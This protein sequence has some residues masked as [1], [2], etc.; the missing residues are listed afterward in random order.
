MREKT[1]AR[2][3]WFV[4]FRKAIGVAAM[5]MCAASAQTMSFVPEAVARNNQAVQLVKAGRNG[6]AEKL[7]RAALSA[8]SSDDLTRAKIASNLGELYRREDRYGEAEKMYRSALQWRE[9]KLPEASVEMAY[10]LNNLGEIYRVEG[11]DWE[12]RSLMMRAERNL[13]EFHSDAPGLPIVQG[14]LAAV[15]CRFGELDQAQELL[16]SA[17]ITY[18]SRR[19]TSSREYGV[20]L[21]GLAR[22]LEHRKDLAGAA[23]VYEEAVGVLK[24]AG[25]S[26]QKELAAALADRGDLY[27]QMDRTAE[28]RQSEERALEL[29]LPQGDALLRAMILRNIGKIVASQG[30]PADSVPYFEQSLALHEKTLGA[31]HPATAGLLL[32]YASATQRAGNK[33][34]ARKLRKRAEELIDRIRSRSPSQMMVSLR[35]LRQEK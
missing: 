18:Q 29:L 3:Q 10:A 17:L 15:L 5:F 14:N 19:Q 31:E 26:A 23:P 4:M 32:D 27:R 22:V 30:K 28:A 24:R 25:P 20:T 8:A 33:G 21:V 7:Y 9:R 12:A 2:N 13:E 6:E 1:R 11:R 35:D 16:R 34:L